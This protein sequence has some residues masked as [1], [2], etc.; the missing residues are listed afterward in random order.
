MYLRKALLQAGDQ[1]EKILKRKIG[2]QPAD[3]VKLRDRLAISRSRGFERFFERH[4]VC[5]RSVLLFAEGTEPAGSYTDVGWIQMAVDVEVSPVPVHA[6]T[7][8]IRHP[9]DS[10]NVSCAVKR[11]GIAVAQTLA[12]EDLLVNR[13]EARVVGLKGMERAH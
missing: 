2:V 7:H 8:G 5:P 12:G 10:E 6:L 9:A 3:N 4:G 13:S 11:E 1:V